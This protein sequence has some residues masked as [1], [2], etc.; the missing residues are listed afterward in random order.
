MITLQGHEKTPDASVGE[1]AQQIGV[2]W[3]DE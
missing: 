1:V 2:A 3:N